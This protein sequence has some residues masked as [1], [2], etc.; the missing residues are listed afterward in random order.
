MGLLDG[1]MPGQPAQAPQGGL[2]GSF[3]GASGTSPAGGAMPPEM[4][5]VV[6]KLKQVDP[7]TQQQMLEQ[8]IGKIK[9]SGQPQPQIEQAIQ[10]L[11]A[12]VQG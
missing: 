3:G 2:L 7:Q 8:I 10:Q 11:V 1:M 4:Q 9:A 12:A 6:E 5:Q